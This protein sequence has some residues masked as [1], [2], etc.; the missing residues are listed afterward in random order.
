MRKIFLMVI[1]LGLLQNCKT[2]I[3]TE[4]LKKDKIMFETFD[5]DKFEKEN[6]RY[7]DPE[8]SYIYLF[9]KGRK[10]WP[11]RSDIYEIPP[12]PYFYL[13]YKEF[14][15]HENSKSTIKEKG[16][17]FGDI[18]LGSNAG[19]KIGYWY[20]FDEKGKLIKEIDED[21][22]FG[23]FGYN[24]VLKFLDDKKDINLHTGEG[25]DKVNI[26]FYYSD[27]SA[28]K[29]WQVKIKSGEPYGVANLP[30]EIGS[31]GGQNFKVY[32]L[33]GNTGE[34]FKIT[35]KRLLDYREIIPG[36]EQQFPWL[37]AS[38]AVYMTHKGK[39][40]TEEEWKAFEQEHHN[41]YLRKRGR[42]DEIKPVDTPKTDDNKRN[43]LADEDDVKPQKKKGLWDSLFD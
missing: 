34:V 16:K 41:E 30:G 7:K 33:D 37:I 26:Q 43:F 3:I 1:I 31:R 15:K 38:T 22:K 6:E 18:D 19:V 36:F 17:Y 25:R 27:K 2:G 23:K 35:D 13:S 12:F 21:K 11:S 24:E 10:V 28:K 39:S 14:Y 4:E 20:Y 5:Y 9:E 8:H 42:E 29:L 40:Y 32:C